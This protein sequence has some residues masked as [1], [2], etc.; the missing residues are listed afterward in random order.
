MWII[1]SRLQF[2]MDADNPKPWAPLCQAKFK[3][4]PDSGKHPLEPTQTVTVLQRKRAA[5]RCHQRRSMKNVSSPPALYSFFLTQCQEL[6]FSFPPHFLTRR[7]H[8][9]PLAKA[10]WWLSINSAVAFSNV[11]LAQMLSWNT[12]LQISPNT[13]GMLYGAGAMLTPLE[14]RWSKQC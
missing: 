8:S 4:L 2:R 6:L 5:E 13:L 14:H 12:G 3:V 9:Q 7:L 1:L 11:I 10:F